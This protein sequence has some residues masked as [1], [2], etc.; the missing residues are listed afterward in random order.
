MKKKKQFWLAFYVNGIE[1][2]AYTIEGTF[3]GERLATINLLASEYRCDK[4]D[5]TTK[6][7]KR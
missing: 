7:I 3:P 1:K 2:M 5:I 6:I 4:N